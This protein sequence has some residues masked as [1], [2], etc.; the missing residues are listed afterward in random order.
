MVPIDQP[1]SYVVDVWAGPHEAVMDLI[2]GLD[3]QRR[4]F[5]KR[6]LIGRDKGED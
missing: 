1:T 6:H 5:K 3:Y 4:K 2:S